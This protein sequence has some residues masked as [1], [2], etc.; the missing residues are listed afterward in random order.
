MYTHIH[1]DGFFLQQADIHTGVLLI[2]VLKA[3]TVAVWAEAVS[4]CM[5]SCNFTLTENYKHLKDYH[6]EGYNEF[7]MTTDKIF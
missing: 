5:I 7:P 6:C 3:D 1:I 2:L 4:S